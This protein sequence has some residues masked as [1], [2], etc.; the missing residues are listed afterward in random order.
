MSR[1][2]VALFDKREEAQA[3]VSELTRMGVGREAISLVT[4]NPGDTD[5][6]Y[7]D[8]DGASKGASV[9]AATGAVAGGVTGLLAGLGLLAIPGIGPFL[10][11]GPIFAALA[12]AGIGAAAGGLIGALVGAGIPE[13][14]AEVYHE[15]IRRGGTLVTVA[16]DETDVE[17]AVDVMNRFHAVDIDRR[18]HEWRSSGWDGKYGKDNHYAANRTAADMPTSARLP[19]QSLPTSTTARYDTARAVRVYTRSGTATAADQAMFKDGAV[20]PETRT[21]HDSLTRDVPGHAASLHDKSDPT[22]R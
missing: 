11:A 13:D 21:E 5:P 4:Q 19:A 12:G 16:A 1:T 3:A 6:T 18:T 15:G 7:S 17:R 14:E 22:R 20:T 9:G 8:A 10:A 2:I